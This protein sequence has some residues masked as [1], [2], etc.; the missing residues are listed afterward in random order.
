MCATWQ[1][2]TLPSGGPIR[3]SSCCRKARTA[4]CV[5]WK[6]AC[7][8]PLRRS[9]VE[10]TDIRLV[11]VPP[12][13]AAALA[14]ALNALDPHEIAGVALVAT[15]SASVRAAVHRLRQAGVS[16]VTLVSDLPNFEARSLCRHRQCG[17]RANSR[18]PDRPVCRTF[19]RQGGGAGR[20]HAGARPC[21]AADGLRAGDAHRI[22]EAR[23]P[24]AD[25]RSRR[26]RHRGGTDGAL[27][28]RPS[29][30]RRHLQPGCRQIAA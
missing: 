5:R 6:R 1:R 30:D 20:L 10:R 22:S 13:D 3:S 28:G 14:A 17:G 19:R 4:S 18:E 7:A 11:A 16:V 8:R 21:R 23:Y 29:R 2:Q 15:E 24:A 12:F 27:P 9:A 26:C 25:R